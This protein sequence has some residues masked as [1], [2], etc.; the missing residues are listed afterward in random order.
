MT[1]VADGELLETMTV[2]RW[3]ELYYPLVF[4]P[5][6]FGGAAQRILVCDPN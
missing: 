2:L 1:S 5:E 4:R 3:P 6:L